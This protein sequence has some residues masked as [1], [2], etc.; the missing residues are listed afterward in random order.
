MNNVEKVN[1]LFSKG[2]SCSQAILAGYSE[3]F[4][5]KEDTALKIA[6]SFGGGIGG[7]RE[8][9]GAVSGALMVIGLKYGRTNEK[10]IESKIKN[11]FYVNEYLKRFTAIYCTCNCKEILNRFEEDNKNK[12]LDTGCSDLVNNA[13]IILEEILN[14]GSVMLNENN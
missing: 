9:C 3:N 5:L 14:R 8:L 4:D 13:A 6:S 7:R 10:D 2:F 1:K 12:I 11:Y